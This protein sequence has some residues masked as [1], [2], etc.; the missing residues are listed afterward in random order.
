[1]SGTMRYFSR[2]EIATDPNEPNGRS[3]QKGAA[4]R[5]QI[6]SLRV[7]HPTMEGRC[8]AIADESRGDTSKEPHRAKTVYSD[9]HGW[10]DHRHSVRYGVGHH[11]SHHAT[12]RPER[13]HAGGQSA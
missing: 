11:T 13:R 5:A 9:S 4:A 10:G 7:S 8:D 2:P 1:M 12:Q 6:G 3:A